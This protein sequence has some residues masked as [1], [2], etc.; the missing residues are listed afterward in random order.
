MYFVGSE[1]TWESEV[2]RDMDTEEYQAH[3]DELLE[4]ISL[5]RNGFAMFFAKNKA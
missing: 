1:P 2:K 4:N 3:L 5:R